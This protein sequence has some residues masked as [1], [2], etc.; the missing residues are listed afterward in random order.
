[1]AKLPED[2]EAV[3]DKDQEVE[4]LY[5]QLIIATTS[6][7]DIWSPLVHQRAR[8]L[9]TQSL[10][11]KNMMEKQKNPPE[12]TWQHNYLFSQLLHWTRDYGSIVVV[13]QLQL[14]S[15]TWFTVIKDKDWL[16]LS[17]Q[18]HSEFQFGS[19]YLVVCTTTSISSHETWKVTYPPVKF[20]LMS[21]NGLLYCFPV[22]IDSLI[23][24]H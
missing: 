16:A 22:K 12:D 11:V 24:T 19:I 21:T 5:T 20:V 7:T 15:I 13:L 17:Y 23:F 8:D 2:G 1:V 3:D 4:P 10:L 14:L 18:K 9:P 6:R